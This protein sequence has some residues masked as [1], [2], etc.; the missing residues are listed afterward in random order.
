MER[1]NASRIS[2]GFPVSWSSCKE[3][4]F[5]L[6]AVGM[7]IL[8]I[9]TPS[10]AIF[11]FFEKSPKAKTA[12]PVTVPPEYKGKT[13]PAGWNS[14]PK[15]L[16]AGKAIFE[17]KMDPRIHCALCHGENGQPTLIGKGAPDLSDPARANEPLDR[18]FWVVSEGKPHTKM[19]GFK[20]KLT[21]QQ[22]WQVIAYMRSFSKQ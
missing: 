9:P 8:F 2:H 3:F 5:A 19:I 15:V 21:E 12:V 18:W 11:G 14:D 16:A 6:C 4:V 13:M 20:K 22:R 17:G 10:H 7:F 1:R